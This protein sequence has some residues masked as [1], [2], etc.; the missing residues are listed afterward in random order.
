M[1]VLL[2]SL[3]F[4]ADPLISSLQLQRRGAEPQAPEP[5]LFRA[6]QVAHL[7]AHQRTRPPGM[8]LDHQLVPD[9]HLRIALYPNQLK[10]L[11]LVGSLKAT[12]GEAST[13][14]VSRR[15]ALGGDGL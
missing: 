13:G 3:G 14:S 12:P 6:N 4:P 1:Q 15:G 5:A 7:G 9:A 2:A 11:N 8:F 10:F